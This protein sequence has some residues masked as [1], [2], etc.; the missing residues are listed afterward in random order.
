MR[1]QWFNV[2]LLVLQ[3]VSWRYIQE[4]N[5][6]DSMRHIQVQRRGLSARGVVNCN[7][8][9]QQFSHFKCSVNGVDPVNSVISDSALLCDVCSISVSRN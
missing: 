2:L 4:P 6:T 7:A 5:Y 9:T 3:Q 8:N 1:L